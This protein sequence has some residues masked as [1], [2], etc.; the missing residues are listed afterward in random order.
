MKRIRN[1]RSWT[2]LVL[3][4]LV[5]TLISCGNDSQEG[6]Q[7]Q[8]DSFEPRENGGKNI[9]QEHGN[10]KEKKESIYAQSPQE[11][12]ETYFISEYTG[13][14]Q[15]KMNMMGIEWKKEYSD[16]TTGKQS[17]STI[18]VDDFHFSKFTGYRF[19]ETL[20]NITKY[21]LN[22]DDHD[23]EFIFSAF[24]IEQIGYASCTLTN[25]AS[26][27]TADIEDICIV[28]TEKGWFLV[29]DGA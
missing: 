2:M 14:I 12:I 28:K 10:S 15:R 8:V 1:R 24:D 18:T 3:G 26:G 27:D 5:L 16:Y 19:D 4:L 9:S 13:D 20:E 23:Y 6:A 22:S 7:K 21:W 17:D 29:L 25:E 11:L